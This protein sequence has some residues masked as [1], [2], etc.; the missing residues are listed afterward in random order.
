MNLSLSN[1][2]LCCREL[3]SDRATERKVITPTAVTLMK[4]GLNSSCTFS[5]NLHL[6]KAAENFRRLLRSQEVVQELD[7][8]SG[9][10][11]E[12]SKQLTWNAV[13]R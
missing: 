3:E 12:G 13:F 9:S 10:K 1:L 7:R 11:P 5:F 4:P 2:L 6:Q 8:T